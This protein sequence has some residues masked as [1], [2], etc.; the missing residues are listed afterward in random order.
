MRWNKH[1]KDQGRR[2]TLT[3]TKCKAS[4][5]Y[6][7]RI[8]LSLTFNATRLIVMVTINLIGH[9]FNKHPSRFKSF[10]PGYE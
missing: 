3:I 2:V 10:F 9:R 1:Y 6:T 8:N 7:Y 4:W 5:L